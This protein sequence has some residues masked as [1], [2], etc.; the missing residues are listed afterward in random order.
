[1]PDSPDDYAIVVGID[2][3]HDGTIPPLKGCVNDARLFERWLVH[4][5]GGNLDPKNVKVIVSG[6][7]APPQ[8]VKDDIESTMI[9]LIDAYQ[10][11]GRRRRRLY[12]WFSGHGVTPQGPYDDCAV[13][14]INALRPTGLGRNIPGRL[15]AERLRKRAIFKEV[16]LIM[17]CC[18]EVTDVAEASLSF[19]SGDDPILGPTTRWFY[20]L[21]TQWG[22]TTAE[23]E[24]PDP[25]DPAAPRLWQGVFTHAVVE[26]LWQAADA[27]GEVTTESLRNHVRQRT[28]QLAPS[29]RLPELT[30]DSNRPPMVLV[31]SIPPSHLTE[32]RI[33]VAGPN[34]GVQ[35]RDGVNIRQNVTAPI[36]NVGP[37]R[38]SIRLGTGLYLIATPAAG[39]V[40]AKSAL[41]EVTGAIVDVPL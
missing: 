39:D 11:S 15:A 13:L 37:G 28:L 6:A 22:A 32:V 9:G 8:P 33:N 35:I 27:N 26:A 20:G 40:F 31:P 17:D 18:R 25:L 30:P 4:K 23:R 21:A 34:G 19:P 41:V 29:E 14:M 3:Y 38:Y 2:T 1:V 16:V 5:E 36:Q 7:A 12:L 24:L 10:T